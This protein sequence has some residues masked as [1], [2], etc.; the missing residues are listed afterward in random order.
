LRL[1]KTL[2]FL[3]ITL[4]WLLCSGKAQDSS[5]KSTGAMNPLEGRPDA[6]EAGQKLF[7][8]ACSG[9]HGAHAEGGR[10]PNLADG[11]LIRRRDDQRLFAS[12]RNGVP[13]ADMPPSTLPDAQ[14]WQLLAYIRSLSA[15]AAESY[16]AGDP[17]TGKDVF[18]G[19]GGCGHCHMILGRGGVLGPDLSNIGMSRSW[20][21]LKRALL[22]PKSRSRAGFQ[23]VTVVTTRG[24]QI[25]GIVKDNTNY[26]VE[27][28]D[29][30]GNLHLLPMQDVRELIFRR[31]SL[32]PGDYDRRLTPKEID[33][34]LAYL[35]RQSLRPIRVRPS[36]ADHSRNPK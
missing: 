7:A 1:M 34:V 21:Q 9:C 30:E 31:G 3:L 25:T 14:I 23:G 13:G 2:R 26:S 27:V 28:Q 6:I 35:S 29:A 24:P 10:G 4:A 20:K 32:M 8:G 12:I 17:E 22:D 36:P 19:K 5:Q 33:D 11:S 15:P 18:S 16:V